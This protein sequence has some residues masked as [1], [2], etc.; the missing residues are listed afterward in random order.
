M[1]I[2]ITQEQLNSLKLFSYYLRSEGIDTGN[3]TI[4][5]ENGDFDYSDF[6]VY[7]SSRRNS[8]EIYSKFK[9]VIIDIIEQNELWEMLDDS[10]NYSEFVFFIDCLER[11]LE[12]QLR[13][14]KWDTNEMIGER[15]F[16][17]IPEEVLNS[18]FELTSKSNFTISFNGGGDSGDIEGVNNKG[19][20]IPN[21][22]L[23][24]LY[25]YL[26]DFYSGWE[27]N[28]GSQGKF[29][30]DLTN[31]QI[32]LEFHENVDEWV[33]HNMDIQIKF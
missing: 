19:E 2:K 12:I 29:I 20:Q 24:Y 11:T 13:E 28:E 32:I 17:D 5:L 21:I 10:D 26:E 25:D 15:E 16:S 1:D 18:I 30:F 22:L 9:K 23:D 14:N 8:V 4:R 33:I 3:F 27:I 6:S 31:E 7:S